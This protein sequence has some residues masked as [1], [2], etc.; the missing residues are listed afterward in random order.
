M[1]IGRN[2][3]AMLIVNSVMLTTF[4]FAKLQKGKEKSQEK[5]RKRKFLTKRKQEKAKRLFC[6]GLCASLCISVI[7]FVTVDI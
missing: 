4:L 7:N 2:L 6:P 1:K 5:L 3:G